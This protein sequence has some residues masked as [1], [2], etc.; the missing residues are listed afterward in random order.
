MYDIFA[1]EPQESLI[2]NVAASKC[3]E[4]DLIVMTGDH[5]QNLRQCILIASDEYKCNFKCGCD[6]DC[7]DKTVIVDAGA[8][9]Q[10]DIII[11]EILVSLP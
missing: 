3:K 10:S 11:C 2:V 6:S 7:N 4:P 8:V 5:N 1:A 9:S